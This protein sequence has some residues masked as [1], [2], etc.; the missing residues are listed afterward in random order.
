MI[1]DI[2]DESDIPADSL[3]HVFAETRH[4]KA[5]FARLDDLLQTPRTTNNA[6]AR[7]LVGPPRCGKTTFIKQ[8][9]KSCLWG[10]GGRR[11]LKHLYVEMTQDTKPSNIASVTLRWMDDPN[12]A[13][14][15]PEQRT[16]RVLN[17]IERRGY[18]ILIFDEAHH[19][20]DTSNRKAQERGVGWVNS[21]LNQTRCPVL[22][23]GYPSL[24]KAIVQHTSLGGRMLPFPPFRTY[25][26]ADQ[27]DL[28]EFRWILTNVEA[29]LGMMQPS[30]LSGEILA[31]RLCIAARGRLG[32]LEL[33][34]TEA[35][36]QARRARHSCL[37]AE[38]LA[39]VTEEF[40][41]TL[42]PLPFNPFRVDDLDKE[43]KASRVDVYAETGS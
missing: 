4:S 40:Y 12:P 27:M 17:T 6:W 21:L 24:E 14:G 31:P 28:A 19:L 13:Y 22:L 38:L 35:R 36:T 23:V 34:L 32:L 9:L 26:H 11:P 25:N 7:A 15:N 8:Y 37:T 5:G 29:Q 2:L 41:P 10:D 39:K 20:L 3:S 30:D 42:G 16:A 43:T 18:D 33:L 1:R